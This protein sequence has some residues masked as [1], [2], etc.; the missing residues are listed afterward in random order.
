MRKL[1]AI[2]V[3]FKEREVMIK[4][5]QQTRS[6]EAEKEGKNVH[7]ICLCFGLFFR[8]RRFRNAQ[9]F[10]F[11]SA[12]LIN[13]IHGGAKEKNELAEVSGEV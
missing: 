3:S 1:V 12:T 10:C 8:G 9:D 4:K 2:D 7:G 11:D 13:T 6:K 5:E